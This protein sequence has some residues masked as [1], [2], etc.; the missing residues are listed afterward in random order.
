MWRL[1]N[2]TISTDKS[3]LDF[4]TIYD[5]ISKESYWGLGRSR[6]F[7][8]R[9]ISNSTFCFGVYHESKDAVKQ[10]GFARVISDL[11]TFGYISD[12]FILRDFRGRGI[13]KWLIDTIINHPELKSLKRIGLFTRT[14]DFY[15]KSK[16]EIFDQTSQPKFLVRKL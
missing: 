7:M 1:T 8:E 13:G 11:T 2:F 10:I 5:F 14:P 6:E 4:D 3:L 16:F 12:V 15:H 9:A